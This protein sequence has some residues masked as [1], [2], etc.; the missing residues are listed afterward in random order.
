MFEQIYD[1]IR[2]ISVYLILTAAVM[3]AVPGKDYVKYI[4]FFSGLV[5]ILLLASPILRVAGVKE[6]FTDIY[7]SAEYETE[8]GEIEKAAEIYETTDLA[9]LWKSEVKGK[10]STGDEI[11]VEEIEIGE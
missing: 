4:R 2:S 10:D 8:R 3:H 9:D 7:R 1:W 6:R 5:L 11:R